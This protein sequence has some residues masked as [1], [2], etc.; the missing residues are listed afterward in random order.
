MSSMKRLLVVSI[1]LAV[2]GIGVATSRW[3][4]PAARAE[5]PQR[6]EQRCFF[7]RGGMGFSDDDEREVAK[8][9]AD[10][11]KEGW[12]LVSVAGAALRQD[13]MFCM[14]RPAR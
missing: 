11:G 1:G 7:H 3:I 12:E 8:Q 6:W 2:G 5:V 9:L 13:F 14:K 4:V 10:A